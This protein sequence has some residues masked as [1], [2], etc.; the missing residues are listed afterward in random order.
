MNKVFSIVR[1][2]YGRSPTDDLKDIDVNTTFGSFFM[3][4]TLQAAVHLG[5]DYTDNPRSTKNQPLKSVRQLFQTTERLIK[6]QTEIQRLT[7]I[8]WKQPVC[9]ETSLLC[10][11]AVQ[12]A[13]SKTYV[14]SDSVL[15]LGNI[16]DK[17]VEAWE[18]RIKWFSEARYLKD[19]DRIDGEP[20]E[21]EWNIFPGFSTLG[22]LAEIQKMMTESKCEP[23]QIK[24]KNNHFHVDV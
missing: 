21:F 5:Q 22:I 14:F 9:K 2:T 10:D 3:S 19:L 23:E 12:I 24:K 16:S 20:T 1:Q 11:R 8:D 7:T 17:P 6:D 15:C 4:V 13:N 18:D